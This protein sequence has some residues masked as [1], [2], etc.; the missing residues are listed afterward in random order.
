MANFFDE[1]QVKTVVEQGPSA[2]IKVDPYTASDAL[3]NAILDEKN[4]KPEPEAKMEESKKEE[5][6][7]T[8]SV[9]AEEEIE[10]SEEPSESQQTAAEVKKAIFAM[11][12]DQ[13]IELDPGVRFKQKVDG[14]EQEVSLQDLLN[15]FSGQ[16]GWQKKFTELDK[17]RQSYLKDAKQ[18]KEIL[19]EFAEKARSTPVEAFEYLAEMAGIN[20]LE[21]RKQLRNQVNEKFSSYSNMSEQ[22][23]RMFEMEEELQYYKS[24][25]ERESSRLQ[26]EQASSDFYSQLENV[27]KQESISDSRL[28]EI[29]NDLQSYGGPSALTVDNIVNLNKAYARQDRVMDVLEKFQKGASHDDLK[30]NTLDSLLSGNSSLTDEQLIQFASNLWNQEVKKPAPSIKQEPKKKSEA[31]PKKQPQNNQKTPEPD[32]FPKPGRTPNFF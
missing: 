21:F 14:E 8:E 20:P 32:Y 11:L 10:A 13:K 7:E 27:K 16:K 6:Q 9:E 1:P 18:V 17:E 5:S 4:S 12:N 26:K 25:K 15:D 2:Q 22:E 24:L 19:N 31:Q 30:F 28:D 3:F 23:R 29:M